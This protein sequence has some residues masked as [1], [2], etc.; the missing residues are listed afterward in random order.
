MKIVLDSNILFSALIKDST[1]REII[2]NY[3]GLFL[4]PEFI[5]EEM[6]KYMGVLRKKSKLNEKEFQKL[7]SI[8]L[9]KVLI[10]PNKAIKPFS[11]EALKIVKD[12]DEND[13]IFF[14]CVLAYHDA[15]L[16]SNDKKLKEQDKVQ[17]FNTKEILELIG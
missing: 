12:L 13:V 6:E 7:L 11:K 15:I 1:T 9:K 16:W 14:A 8:I 5:F 4:F 10:I 17:V 3:Q 2:L